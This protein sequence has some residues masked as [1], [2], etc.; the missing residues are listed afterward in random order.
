[1]PLLLRARC[2]NHRI[3][4]W[5]GVDHFYLP[6][7]LTFY[8]TVRERD[9]AAGGR[10][11]Y[12]EATGGEGEGQGHIGACKVEGFFRNQSDFELIPCALPSVPFLPEK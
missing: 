6:F 2:P 1:M 7:S 3:P 9:G 8:F 4:T 10:V 5:R 12:R 11:A